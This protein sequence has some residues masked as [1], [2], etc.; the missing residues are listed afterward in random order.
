MSFFYRFYGCFVASTSTEKKKKKKNIG[1]SMFHEGLGSEFDRFPTYDPSK[2]P[3]FL[4]A[5]DSEFDS[6]SKS[7][8]N[9]VTGAKAPV[10]MKM[11]TCRIFFFC[12]FV[13]EAPGTAK[14]RN[15]KR[16]QIISLTVCAVFLCPFGCEKKPWDL[17][18]KNPNRQDSSWAVV[19]SP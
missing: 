19:P 1:T 9:H 10:W 14:H 12:H 13:L 5:K 11:I 3:K 4:F 16:Y 2:T 7:C 18:S 8:L 15:K 17:E 6:P